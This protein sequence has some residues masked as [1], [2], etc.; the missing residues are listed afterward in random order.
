MNHDFEAVILQAL[1]DFTERLAAMRKTSL[2]FQQN[3]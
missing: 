1:V 2:H 3:T